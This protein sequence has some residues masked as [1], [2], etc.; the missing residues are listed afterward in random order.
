MHQQHW[1]DYKIS[2]SV[3]E[4][5]CHTK[6]GERSTDRNLP[7]MFTKLATKVDSQE[8]WLPI[9]LVKIQNISVSHIPP[10]PLGRTYSLSQWR[11]FQRISW[12]PSVSSQN[13]TRLS[14][15][16]NS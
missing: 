11:A 13:L 16:L 12:R 9:V 1:T 10:K 15:K 7:S 2:L 5:V 6:R 4:W 3:S 8:M 14:K